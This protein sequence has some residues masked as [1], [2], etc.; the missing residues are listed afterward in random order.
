MVMTLV[1]LITGLLAARKRGEA[2][3]SLGLRRTVTKLMVY[4][5]LVCLAFITEMYLTGPMVPVVKIF[6]GFIG[7]TELKSVME[8]LE[9]LTGMPLIKTLIDKLTNV[10]KTH[11]DPPSP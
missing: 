1:D 7:L 8:N 5:L 6:A 2:V 11:D 10:E 4:E 9:T 3:T